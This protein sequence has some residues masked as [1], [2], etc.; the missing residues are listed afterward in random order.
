MEKIYVIGDVHGRPKWQ[1]LKKHKVDKFIFIGD[2]FDSFD[3]NGTAQIE[4]FKK[5]IEFKKKYPDKVVL[6]I[7][8]HD[9]HYLNS[10][11]LPYSGFQKYLYREIRDILEKNIEYLQ[12]SYLLT[13]N[14]EDYLFT[15][16]GVTKTWCEYNGIDT[17]S[18]KIDTDINNLFKE[19]MDAFAFVGFDPYGDS[20]ESSPIWVRPKS[21]LYNSIDGFIQIV[22]HTTQKEVTVLNVKNNTFV[23][24]DSPDFFTTIDSSGIFGTSF[25]KYKS[26]K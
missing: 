10:N 26:N 20:Y 8:N 2:Y 6:M 21:L 22:G 1:L 12:M 13:F 14:D 23:F 24:A 18:S 16:A 4:N 5:I 7:G 11:E 9:Y 15:H 19:N 17:L 25:D 3:I